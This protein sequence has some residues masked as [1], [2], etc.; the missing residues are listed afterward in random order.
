[1]GSNVKKKLMAFLIIGGMIGIASAAT[2]SLSSTYVSPNIET[3]VSNLL[4]DGKGHWYVLRYYPPG[5]LACADIEGDNC[6]STLDQ[7]IP[8]SGYVAGTPHFS[9]GTSNDHYSET[10][11][12]SEEGTW[13]VSL[14]HSGSGTG[15]VETLIRSY[16]LN[17]KVN[18]PI[19]EFP[20]IAMPVAAAL[21]IMFLMSRR[22]KKE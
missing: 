5:S 13:V 8:P 4:T 11:A 14:W 7:S 19:P 20:T 9:N 10:F 21:G 16:K 2:E 1:M 17:T 15:G 3:T 12:V 6:E 18:V 22:N